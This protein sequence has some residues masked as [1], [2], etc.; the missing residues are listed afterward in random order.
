MLR[1]TVN[2]LSLFFMQKMFSEKRFWVIGVCVM[3]VAVL[4]PFVFA[5]AGRNNLYVNKNASGTE[6]GSASHPYKTIWQALDKADESTD[7]FVASGEYKESITIGKGVRV[8]GAGKDKTTIKA[9]NSK[10]AVVTMKHKS[11]LESVTV[12]GGKVGIIVKKDSRADISK[13]TI[14]D[15]DNE[16]ILVLEGD[17]NSDKKVSIVK[18]SISDNGRSGIYA[19]K[20]KIVVMDSKIEDN[21]WNGI[22]FE[23]NVTGWLES[24]TIREN[25]KSGVAV[26]LDKSEIGLKKNS[27]YRNALEGIEVSAYG[28]TGWVNVDRTKL[29]ENG[30]YGLAK[31]SRGNGGVSALKGLTVQGNVE[32]WGNG[33]GSV[34]GVIRVR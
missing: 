3:L 28:E 7:I 16:G 31:L 10:D 1:L 24:N 5:E 18:C 11:R 32:Y 30:H 26:V 27:L 29:Y 23:K 15:N 21:V 13:A 34:S 14:K 4:M 20:R 22:A 33:L 17:T 25:G 6:D 19:L 8:Y 9:K 2:F 12:K